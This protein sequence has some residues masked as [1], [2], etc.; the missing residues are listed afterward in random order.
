[1]PA[2]VSS[3]ADILYTDPVSELLF[4][5]ALRTCI[6]VN[7]AFCFVLPF[8][9]E[10][11]KIYVVHAFLIFDVF[12]VDTTFLCVELV[13]STVEGVLFCIVACVFFL[14]IT[15]LQ[16]VK[17]ELQVRENLVSANIKL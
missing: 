10:T 13:V 17:Y 11:G 14:L 9:M 4:F 6:A 3:K 7:F 2:A 5:L 8:K 15:I 16:H 1:M 12:C